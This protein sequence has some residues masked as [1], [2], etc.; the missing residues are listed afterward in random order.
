MSH[1]ENIDLLTKFG[2][3][4]KEE[5]LSNSSYSKDLADNLPLI[6]QALAISPASLGKNIILVVDH[7]QPIPILIKTNNDLNQCTLLVKHANF[8]NLTVGVLSIL[9]N[10]VSEQIIPLFFNELNK[11][12]LSDIGAN[13]WKLA[14]ISIF[15]SL[16]SGI[17]QSEITADVYEK[18]KTRQIENVVSA[19]FS[20]AG[21]FLSRKNKVISDFNRYLSNQVGISSVNAD[22][23]LNHL[24]ELLIKSDLRLKSDHISALNSL[25]RLRAD[26]LS[27][28]NT[29]NNSNES[30]LTT[31]YSYVQRISLF[32]NNAQTTS[33]MKSGPVI[34]VVVPAFVGYALNKIADSNDQFSALLSQENLYSSEFLPSAKEMQQMAPI[35]SRF[36]STTVGSLSLNGS[37]SD[38]YINRPLSKAD[39]QMLSEPEGQRNKLKM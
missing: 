27:F 13:R 3:D 12:D 1:L 38:D 18:N 16:N 15:E 8:T 22:D 24:K 20:E 6:A 33:K 37:E 23:Q 36:L 5:T 14:E 9:A 21:D 10:S 30:F 29:N 25:F 32:I 39:L 7:K 17:V 35:E 2:F 31:P 34:E 26:A 4:I 19:N 11:K 28:Q